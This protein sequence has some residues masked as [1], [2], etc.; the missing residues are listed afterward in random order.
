V[1]LPGRRTVTL[2]LPVSSTPAKRADTSLD[3]WLARLPEPT[4]EAAAVQAASR[5]ELNLAESSA[6]QRFVVTWHRAPD[7]VEWFPPASDQFSI[8][9]I[10]VETHGLVSTVMFSA[11]PF[12]KTRITPATLDSVLAYTLGGQRKGLSVPVRVLGVQETP[13]DNRNPTR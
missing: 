10:R 3:K 8:S 4:D 2:D 12:A 11:T 5:P 6:T 1:C 13:P 7:S 9:D